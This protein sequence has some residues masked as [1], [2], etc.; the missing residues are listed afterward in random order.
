MD[1]TAI[2]KELREELEHVELAIISIERLAAGRGRRR[3][4]P[5]AW[6]KQITTDAESEGM[7]KRKPGRPPKRKPG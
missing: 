1:V 7:Q 2:L 5:P 4:R 6:M 3:G